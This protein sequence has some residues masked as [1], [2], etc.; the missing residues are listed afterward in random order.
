MDERIRRQEVAEF[1]MNPGLREMRAPR[2]HGRAGER[3]QADHEAADHAM[4]TG[5]GEPLLGNA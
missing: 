4:P 3:Q 2:G 5:T 1:V